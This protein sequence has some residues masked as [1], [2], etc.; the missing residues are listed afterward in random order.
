MSSHVRS[1]CLIVPLALVLASFSGCGEAEPPMA[2]Q[3]E[4]EK[5]KIEREEI[6]QKEYGQ[7]AFKAGEKKGKTKKRN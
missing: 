7:E 5:G 3:E 6:I 1:L 2:T 4:F